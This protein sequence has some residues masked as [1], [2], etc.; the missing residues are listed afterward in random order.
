[1]PDDYVYYRCHR[2]R[3][4]SNPNMMF[5]FEQ[6]DFPLLDL[7]VGSWLCLDHICSNKEVPSPEQMKEEN[8]Q[9]L[10]RLME[11][12]G[13]RYYMDG[14]YYEALAEIPQDHW[15]QDV[16]SD[17]YRPYYAECQRTPIQFLARDMIDA[18]YPVRFG[19]IDGLNKVG[20]K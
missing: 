16:L 6:C 3:L 1:M 2:R 13:T 14:N 5:L 9:D 18:G 7:E 15:Y 11:N 12:P 19:D 20:E 10:V 8:K 4:I 17:D